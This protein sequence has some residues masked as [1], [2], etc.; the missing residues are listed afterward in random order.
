MPA[1]GASLRRIAGIDELDGNT[2][3]AGFVGHKPPQLEVVYSRLARVSG[4]ESPN[5]WQH[6]G[7]RLVDLA[8]IPE[9]AA[10]LDIGTGL[11][12][13]LIPAAEKAGIHGLGIGVDIDFGWCKRALT[14]IQSHNSRRTALAAMDAANLGFING[15]FD[16][17]LCGFVGWDYCFDFSKMKFTGSD[18]RLSEFTRVLRDGGCVG[19]S[20]WERQEDLEWLGEHFRRYFPVYVA[21]QEK[22]TGSVM[23]VYSKE[24]AKGLESILREGSFQ[25]IEIT[26]ETAEFVSTDEEEWW[27]QVWGA[28]WWEHIDRVARMELDELGRFKEQVFENLQQHKYSDGIHFSKTVLFAFGKKKL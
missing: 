21:D 12:S 7:T 2:S 20:S 18:T 17:V 1:Q 28:G 9:G 19:I 5:Y 26:T 16:H 8:E 13:V 4:L 6:F 22:E 25:D 3:Q 27:W 15:L 11:G 24:N 10:V 23:T 14:E